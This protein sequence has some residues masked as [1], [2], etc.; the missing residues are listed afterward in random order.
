M[1][2][3]GEPIDQEVDHSSGSD[4]EDYPEYLDLPVQSQPQRRGK[5]KLRK[6]WDQR[7]CHGKLALDSSIETW[8]R[9]VHSRIVPATEVNSSM[10]V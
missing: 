2:A 5:R 10:S 4:S 1:S 9:S 8:K 6:R 3:D 7:T